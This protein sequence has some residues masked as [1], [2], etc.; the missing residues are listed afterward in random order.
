MKIGILGAGTW[1]VSLA[2][3]LVGNEH[4]VTVWSFSRAEIDEI[5]R[6]GEH[7]NLP[8]NEYAVSSG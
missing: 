4:D 5:V 8:E 2:A 7:R 3:V 1:G 6:T